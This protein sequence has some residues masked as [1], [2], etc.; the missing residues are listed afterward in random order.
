MLS[1]DDTEVIEPRRACAVR[2]LSSDDAGD[3]G[4]YQQNGPTLADAV[5]PALCHSSII[6]VSI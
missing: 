3:D 2:V 6:S 4:V 5:R 1:I